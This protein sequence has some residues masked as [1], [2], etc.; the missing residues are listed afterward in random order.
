[1]CKYW[2]TDDTHHIL[3][4]NNLHLKKGDI[5]LIRD[6]SFSVKEATILGLMGMSGSGKTLTS[7]ALL[8][9]LGNT[10]I[11][12]AGGQVYFHSS[13]F[14]KTDISR[15]DS[16]TI[17]RIRTEEIAFIFQDTF[18][19]LNPLICCGH[20]IAAVIRH[21]TGLPRKEARIAAIDALKRVQIYNPEEVYQ[22]FPHQ[23][24]GGQRQRVLIAMAISTK[25]RL[26]IADEPT[27]SLDVSRQKQ[28][29]GILEAF[30]DDYGTSV[31]LISHELNAIAEVADDL[32]V[33][34]NGTVVEDGDLFQ[35]FLKPN[36][37]YTK[38]LLACRPR[39][40]IRLKKLPTLEDFNHPSDSVGQVLVDHMISSDDIKKQQLARMQH[41]PLLEVNGLQVTFSKHAG[42]SSFYA[43]HDFSL[44]L[45]KGETLGIVG[46][47]GSGKTTLA[48]VLTAL[49]MPDVADIVLHNTP[50]DLYLK[51][52]RNIL[53]SNVQMIF[54][55]ARSSI[56]PNKTI[57]SSLRE[58]A[59]QGNNP[60]GS[61]ISDLKLVL[62]DVG[63][64]ASF[65]GRY[66]HQCSGGQL[67][68]IAIARTL[69]MRPACIICDEIVASLDVSTQAQ[70]L[71]LLN[72]L[73]ERYQLTY[74]FISHDLSV[75]RFMTDRVMVMKN[76]HVVESGLTEDVFNWPNHNYTRE[77]LQSVP[78]GNLQ[79]IRE[80]RM[81]KQ[82]GQV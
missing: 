20:Q 44:K 47:S 33:L 13:H 45:F 9:L 43:L 54:Q 26:I 42:K 12:M 16:K 51:A 79:A 78:S 22:R 53:R 17:N 19:S 60:E 6:V 50:L 49:I 40:D 75:I 3:E 80:K 68:R 52:H 24:S 8:Q 30:R 5:S 76:G 70:V 10:G 41:L 69:I 31:V 63:L 38:G 48:R 29:L 74:I 25:P 2:M 46:E 55:D 15:A 59:L 57:A 39:M 32:L 81:R 21:K 82:A 61:A 34:K 67:Q 28:I 27:S 1:M 4:V 18:G 7:Y 72:M 66:P 23:L 37:L 14:G 35:V 77:L 65:L 62:E 56:N 11:K 58:A 71:N 64:D 73:K 36:H